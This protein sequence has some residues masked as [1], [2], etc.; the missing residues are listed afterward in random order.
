M[1]YL[2]QA[3][4]VFWAVLELGFQPIRA[5]TPNASGHWSI[6]SNA[7]FLLD[8]KGRPFFLQGD[9]AWSL[10]ANLTDVETEEYLKNRHAKGFNTLLVNL[11][12]HKFSKHPPL[13]IAGN[14]PFADMT[15]WSRP[16]EKYFTHADWVVEKASEYGLVILLAPVYLGYVGTDEGFIEEIVKTGKENALAYG[17]FLGARYAKYDNIIWVMGGDRNPGAAI[18]EIDAIAKGIRE[19]DHRH[20]FTAHCHPDA[21]PARTVHSRLA[22]LRKHIR[23]S[24]RS[25]APA[26][27]L[28]PQTD[29]AQLSD[30]DHLRGRA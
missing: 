26:S 28:Q 2:C 27:R 20:L 15:N 3:F 12:E 9:A 23:L 10:I 30:G 7:H 24:N 5:E 25:S 4:F 1:R 19:H 16:N 8:T 11:I 21:V 18:D 13:D 17:R 22:G 14:A 29:S 6:S